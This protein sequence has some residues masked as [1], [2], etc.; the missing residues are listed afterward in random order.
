MPRERLFAAQFVTIASFLLFFPGAS[1]ADS[2]GGPDSD[3][4]SSLSDSG[5]DSISASPV[6][7]PAHAF[8]D[9]VRVGSFVV[10]PTTSEASGDS[11]EDFGD[12][13]GSSA[14]RSDS[15][16]GDLIGGTL[17]PASLSLP[18]AQGTNSSTTPALQAIMFFLMGAGL[19]VLILRRGLVI[20]LCT[21]HGCVLLERVGQLRLSSASGFRACVAALENRFSHAFSTL[22]RSA[23]SR[24]FPSI[25]DTANSKVGGAEFQP[26]RKNRKPQWASARAAIMRN[27]LNPRILGFCKDVNGAIFNFVRSKALPAFARFSKECKL[28]GIE[29]LL[30]LSVVPQLLRNNFSLAAGEPPRARVDS[31]RTHSAGAARWP[32]VRKTFRVASLLTA[33]R[34]SSPAAKGGIIPR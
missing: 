8:A 14:G 17:T 1:L 18:A 5:S 31:S 12:R 33:G 28:W 22:N 26:Y 20:R 2:A 6:L 7:D 29:L 3:L 27:P 11:P 30:R 13:S 10:D 23:D 25:R 4:S 19:A 32:R 9:H 34:R 16:A 15:D 24:G 21:K